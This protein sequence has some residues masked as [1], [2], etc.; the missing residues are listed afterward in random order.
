MLELKLKNVYVCGKCGAL[1]KPEDVTTFEDHPNK[2]VCKVC[3]KGDYWDLHPET[4]DENNETMIQSEKTGKWYTK[5]NWSQ[6]GYKDY[7]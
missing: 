3:K 5:W 2:F 7:D 6:Y 1:H 4:V